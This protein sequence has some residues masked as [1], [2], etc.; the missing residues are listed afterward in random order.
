MLCLMFECEVRGVLATDG[1]AWSDREIAATIPGE[2]SQILSCIDELLRK[3]VAHRNGEGAIHNR[4]MVHDENIRQIRVESGKKGGN[5]ALVNQNHGL[6][7][8]N[9]NQS[10]NQTPNQNPT[11]SSS[12][13]TSS[14]KQ[15]QKPLR[16]AKANAPG[17]LRHTV[18]RDALERYWHHVNAN[19]TL[20]E[21][22]WSARTAKALSDL[23][24]ASPTLDVGAFLKLLNY[25]SQSEVNQSEEPYVWLRRVTDYAAGPLDRFGKPKGNG[26]GTSVINRAQARTDSNKANARAVYAE[27]F[28]MDGNA[29]RG[30]PGEF[31]QGRAEGVRDLSGA[32]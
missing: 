20:P 13:S 29:G 10:S 22:P 7:N 5:P 31:E 18:F 19:T 12:S 21:L 9:A 16:A 15:R 11:P 23:L 25:R 17:D 28:G 27:M 3:G 32:I 26:N 1:V 8:Q 30:A 2:T 24:S 4:R 6:L 14:S